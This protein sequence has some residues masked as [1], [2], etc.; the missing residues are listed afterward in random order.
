MLLSQIIAVRCDAELRQIRHDISGD[1]Q[2]F[3][4]W[5]RYAFYLRKTLL[6]T[7]VHPFLH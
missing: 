7:T 4:C 5:K 2:L 1:Y 6:K 3:D